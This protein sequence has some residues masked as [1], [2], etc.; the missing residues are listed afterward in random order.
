MRDL[1][2]FKA[3]PIETIV[4]P[5]EIVGLWVNKIYYFFKVVYIEPVP[6]SD[7]I[8]QNFG[9]LAAAAPSAKTRVTLLDMPDVEFGQF[10]GFVIDDVAVD[11]FL[12]QADQRY[13]LKNANARLDRFTDLRDPCG[14]TTEFYVYQDQSA[15]MIATN[16]TGYANTQSRAAFYG[17]RYVLEA[18]IDARGNAY[19]WSPG[20][21][22]HREPPAWT[23]VP[24]SAHL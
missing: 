2:P 10:R 11:L 9:I 12:A 17:F 18:A 5:D 1:Y 3:G 4:L 20:K 23:R 15:Y 22:E 8:Q 13:K 7:P 6:R 24:C 21:P 14:H 19:K 16:R